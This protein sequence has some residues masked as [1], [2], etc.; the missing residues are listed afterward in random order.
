MIRH[1]LG[2]PPDIFITYPAKVKFKTYQTRW[3]IGDIYISGNAQNTEDNPQGSGCYLVMSGRG[4]NDIFRILNNRGHSF[5]DM[6]RRCEHWFNADFHFTRLDIAVDDRNEA[7]FFT[8]QQIRKK[9]EKDEYV[10]TSEYC[11]FNDSKY[12]GEDLARTTYIGAGKSGIS[13]RFYDKDKEVSAKYNKPIEEIGSWKRTEIQLRDEKAHSFAMLYK[14]NPLDLGE[15][16]FNVLA[17]NLRFVV[18]DKN[19]SNKSR[20]KTCRFWERFLGAVEP[21]KLHISQP[22][23]SLIETQQWLETGGVLSAVKGFCFLEEHDALGELDRVGDMLNKV[24][25]S[26]AFAAKLTGHL[27]RIKREELIPYVK[28]E[29]KG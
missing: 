21:L 13:Y 19:E 15:L 20:W 4:C 9:C 27:Q 25:Y 1:V 3:Q 14:E 22:K 5:G 23:N 16:A 26:P 8:P 17:G 28:Y 11:R 12:S 7:P 24:R 6:F 2:L 10:S 29:T 18:P